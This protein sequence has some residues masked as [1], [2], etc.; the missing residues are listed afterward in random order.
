MS[1]NFWLDWAGMTI[2]LINTILLIWLGLTVLLNAE[3]RTW[4]AWVAGGGLILGGFFFFGHS[5][6]LGFGLDNPSRGLNFW[7]SVGWVPVVAL[8]FVWYVIMLWYAGFWGDSNTSLYRRQKSWFVFT[9]LLAIL[10]FGIFFLANPLSSYEDIGNLD[11]IS[12]PNLFGIPAVILLYPVYIMLNIALSLDA[13][14]RPGPT[15]RVMGD[16][17]RQRARPWLIATS[18]ALLLVSL[19][20]ATVI[21]WILQNSGGTRLLFRQAYIVAWFDLSIELLIGAATITLGQAI[22]AYEIFTGKAL[23]RRGSLRQWRRAIILAVGY[24]ALVSW[25]LANNIRPIYSLLLT[26]LLMTIF[27]ALLSWR[28]YTER[29]RYIKNLRPFVSSQGLFDQI[30]T[31]PLNSPTEIDL[32]TPFEALCK[33]VLGTQRAF[34]IAVGSLAP[35]VGS[36]LTYPNYLTADFDSMSQIVRLFDSPQ[37]SWVAINPQQYSGAT[38]AVPLW[39]E[40]GLIGILL[41]GEKR[42]GGLYTQ[43]EI[44]IAQTSGERL[45]DTKASSE[46]SQRLMVLQRQRLAESQLIDQRTRRVLHDEVL[47]QLHAAMLKLVSEQSKPNGGTSEVIEMLAGAHNQISNLL[48]DMPTTTL[49]EISKLGLV[50][51]LRKVV[52]EEFGIAFEEVYW[53]VE[54]L[55]ERETQDISSLTAEVLYYAAREAIRNAAR[56]GSQGKGNRPLHLKISVM[57]NVK[58]GGIEMQ[59]EDDGM[60]VKAGAIDNSSSGQGLALHSTMMAVVGGELVFE[61]LPGEY[62]RV[63]LTLPTG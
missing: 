34:L 19:L 28:S 31:K 30:L 14:R 43:E 42:D 12:S 21:I 24:G 50:G 20:V 41:L 4:G 36:H 8:P 23:P 54:P 37:P 18:L 51:A 16:L 32:Q 48:R 47:Q 39:S 40:R 7:W 58:Y 13:L 15:E 46:I 59:I 52:E 63:S 44:E 22:V 35:L 55:A 33:D 11:S 26:T 10:L 60:G 29:E 6:I 61:S 17:A 3:R 45:I 57:Q 9:I 2:S 25:S 62:T 56:H 27:Y 1:N 53:N 5:A 49:P 38:W